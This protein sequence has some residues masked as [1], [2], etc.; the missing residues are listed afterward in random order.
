MH[1]HAYTQGRNTAG[2]K[3]ESVGLIDLYDASHKAYINKIVLLTK[4][5]KKEKKRD[6]VCRETYWTASSLVGVS[7]RTLIAG[8]RFGRYSN[9]SRVGKVKAAVY[10]NRTETILVQIISQPILMV[11]EKN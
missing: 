9:L 10:R 4:K 6:G 11:P 7:I 2:K 1:L 5:F 8:T 3:K